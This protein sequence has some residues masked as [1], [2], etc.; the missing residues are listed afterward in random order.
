M[1]ISAKQKAVLA[2]TVVGWAANCVSGIVILKTYSDRLHLYNELLEDFDAVEE[3]CTAAK[4]IANKALY[5]SAYLASV[6][7]KHG[8]ELS[9]FDKQVISDPPGLCGGDIPNLFAKVMD[10]PN[11]LERLIEEHP[12]DPS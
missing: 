6:L 3:E 12:E 4:D 5:V 11:F 2:F 9:E 8:I 7:G 1:T 10:D